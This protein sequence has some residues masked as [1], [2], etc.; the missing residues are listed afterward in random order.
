MRG[1]GF[2]V[3]FVKSAPRSQYSRMMD[4]LLAL[5]CD[6]VNKGQNVVRGSLIAFSR[7]HTDKVTSKRFTPILIPW[8]FLKVD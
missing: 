4:G 3:R 8:R 1:F 5:E 6:E 2:S 7:S